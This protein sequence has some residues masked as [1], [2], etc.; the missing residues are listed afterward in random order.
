MCCRSEIVNG[1]L[2]V[3]HCPEQPQA[4]CG[5]ECSHCVR[6]ELGL[7]PVERTLRTFVF[8]RVR[9]RGEVTCTPV[10][11]WAGTFTADGCPDDDA[12]HGPCSSPWQRHRTRGRTGSTPRPI[13]CR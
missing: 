6:E 5:A 8:R 3:Q 1:A 12:R 2:A 13:P 10:E 4:A 11:A 9:H 7:E